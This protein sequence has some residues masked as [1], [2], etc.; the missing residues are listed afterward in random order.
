MFTK[1]H[2][3]ILT[4]KQVT[5]SSHVTCDSPQYTLTF[6]LTKPRPNS[7]SNLFFFNTSD[8]E[9]IKSNFGF[10]QFRNARSVIFHPQ[11]CEAL[12]SLAQ[13]MSTG[14]V[15]LL[16]LTSILPLYDALIINFLLCLGW[17]CLLHRCG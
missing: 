5:F 2:H 11:E 9:I 7:H 1:F 17:L 13:M 16:T 4:T 6:S 3:Y 10:A 15:S 14:Y 8:T 12:E